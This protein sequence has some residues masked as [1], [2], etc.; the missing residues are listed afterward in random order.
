MQL[1]GDV[2]G[3]SSLLLMSNLTPCCYNHRT[4]TS[5]WV[6]NNYSRKFYIISYAKLKG[7][8]ILA[9]RLCWASLEQ[10]WLISGPAAELSA[11][12]CLAT[13]FPINSKALAY[14]QLDLKDS[15]R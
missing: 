15:E 12:K 5:N 11:A 10:L 4:T 3:R 2:I 13:L 6:E 8:Y 7:R 1:I 9:Y 14:L